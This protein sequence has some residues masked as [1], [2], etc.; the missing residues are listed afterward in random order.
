MF[1]WFQKILTREDT[2]LDVAKRIDRIM[3]EHL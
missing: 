2:F 3:L 1:G